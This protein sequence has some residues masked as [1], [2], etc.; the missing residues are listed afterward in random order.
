MEK[1]LGLSHFPTMHNL[2]MTQREL[3]SGAAA[4]T[5]PGLCYE[6]EFLSGQ[7][8]TE[9]LALI[10]GLPFQQAQYKEW[11]ARRRIVSFG[12]RY[13]FT[14]HRLREAPPIPDSL[15]PLRD[16]I[17]CFANVAPERIEHAMIAQYAPATPL[18]WHR[19]VADFE[20]IMGVSLRGRARLRFRPWPP[21]PNARTAFAIDLAPRS[22]YVLRDEVRW[23]WQHA[24]S[25]TKELRYSITFRTRTQ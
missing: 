16:R 14:R 2:P 21:Q 20:V 12:G 5:L 8:E 24:V 19:D 13:D 6:P 7:E 15:L 3:F 10:G 18:G 25:P 22:A 1:S 17:A 4:A 23:G 11:H 9:L